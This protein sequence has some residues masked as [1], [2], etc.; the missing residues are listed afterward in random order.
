[1]KDPT[2]VV[3][4]SGRGERFIASGAAG[5]KLHALLRGRRVIDWTLDAVRAT[6]LP[7]HVEDAGH[8]GMGDSIAAAVRATRGAAGWLILPADLPLITPA[9]IEA[10]ADA[11]RNGAQAV[12]PSVAGQAAHPVGFAAAL[13]EKLENLGGNQGAAGVLLVCS[14]INLIVND[15]GAV[16]DVDTLEDLR[17]MEL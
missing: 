4:A 11:L 2:V 5:N 3:L 12:R 1:V 16:E 7:F 14:A 6:G 17:R 13:R 10:V 15:R 9:T 8:P